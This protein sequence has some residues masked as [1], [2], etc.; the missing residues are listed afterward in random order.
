M[1]GKVT[2]FYKNKHETLFFLLLTLMNNFIFVEDIF[3]LLQ[4]NKLFF[5]KK[6]ETP[7]PLISNGP[8]LTKLPNQ[9]RAPTSLCVLAH[10]V[11]GLQSFKRFLCFIEKVKVINFENFLLYLL[12]QT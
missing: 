8:S 9:A 4:G 10:T 2:Y 3:S 12:C 5:F 7:T 1:K 6:S 11:I